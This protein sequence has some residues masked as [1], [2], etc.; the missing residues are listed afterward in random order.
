[1]ANDDPPNDD[2]EAIIRVLRDE[3]ERLKNEIARLRGDRD[4]RPPHYL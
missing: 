4:E 2:L 1:M 3:I